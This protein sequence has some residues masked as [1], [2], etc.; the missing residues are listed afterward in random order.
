MRL[1]VFALGLL[2]CGGTTAA[3]DGGVDASADAKKEASPLDATPDVLDAT[4]G[5][6]G[7]VPDLPDAYA[8]TWISPSAP[9]AA[10]TTTQI[11]ELYDDCH[12]PN[13]SPSACNAFVAVPANA[14]CQSCMETPIGS[15]TYGAMIA[16]HDGASLE[17]NIGGCMA[18]LDGDLGASGCGTKYEAWD[19]CVIAAC[20]Y[21]PGGT[22]E[23]CAVPARS[24]PCGASESAAQ[25]CA[26][27]PTY[28]TC[29]SQP[30]FED[31]F[32][33]FG[34]MFCAAD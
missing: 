4:D 13:Q 12:G 6:S 30:T 10:C 14:T 8:P 3:S 7:C 5:S 31:F 1:A 16:W 17:A 20:S 19:G 33:T 32:K 15:T 26:N 18:L 22:Y 25:T 24:G 2:A 21:C 9:S 11:Q 27:D 23:S 34:A 29:V 28:A